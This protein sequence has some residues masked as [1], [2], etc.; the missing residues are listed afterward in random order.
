MAV[1]AAYAFGLLLAL[2]FAPTALAQTSATPPTLFNNYFVTGDYAVGGV[3]LRGSGDATGYAMGYITIPDPNYSNSTGVPAG[4]DIVGA[5]L[6]WQTVESSQT[7]FAGQQG[8]FRAL[9]A[10]TPSAGYP[11]TGFSLGN[12]NAPVSWSSG[13]CAGA[14][15]GSK[16]IRTYRADVRGYLPADPS[17]GMIPSTYQVRLADSGSNGGG[18]PL[19]LGATLVIIYR[20]LPAVAVRPLNAIVI[21]DGSYAPSNA[22]QTT[23]L[24]MQG[25]YQ[26]T[27]LPGT[28]VAKLTQ[29]VGNGQ[30]NKYEQVFI[31]GT[32]LTPANTAAF[33]GAYNGSWDNPTWPVTVNAADNSETISVVPSSSNAGCVSWGAVILSTT[34]QDSDSDGLLDI[35]EKN[36]GY[37]D[38]MDTSGSCDS[39]H[40]SWVDLSGA[41]PNKKDVFIQMDYMCNGTLNADGTC[42][43]GTTGHSHMPSAAAQSALQSAFSA[44]N[45]NVHIK[46]KNAILEQTC[47]DNLTA[48]PPQYC[49]YP[50]TAGTVGWKYGL[51]YIKYT[52]LNPTDTTC[53]TT[54]VCQRNF[55]YGR[56]DSYHYALFGHAL[57]LPDWSFQNGTL[58][59]VSVSGNVATF[60]TSTPIAASFDRVTIGSA[61]SNPNLNGIFLTTPAPAVGSTTF[62]ITLPTSVTGTVTYTKVT[63]PNLVVASDNLRSGSGFSD[64]G[65]ADSLITLGQWGADGTSTSTV[66]GTFMHELGHS[67]AL[68]HGGTYPAS[69]T[70]AVPLALEPNCKPNYQSVMNYLF[71]V[72]LLGSNGVLDYSS[73]QLSQLNEFSLP[74]S[75][76]TMDG[77]AIAFTSTKWYDLAAPNGVGTPATRHC[78]G[79][80]ILDNA[81]MYRIEGPTSPI[82]WSSN[83]LDI[84]FDGSQTTLRGYNDWA[85]IDLRQIGAT[86]SDFAGAGFYLGGGGIAFTGG[87]IAFTGGGIAFTGGGIAFTGGGIAFTGGGTG[88]IDFDTANSTV[89]PPRKLTSGVTSTL[90][91]SILLN[92]TAPSFGQITSYRIYKGVNAAPGTSPSYSVSGSPLATSYTDTAVVCG[93]LY[94]YFVT[95]V[96]Q[97]ASGTRESAPSNTVTQKACG[98]PYIFTGFY[99]PL[100]AATSPDPSGQD[101][102]Y[103]GAFNI[104]KSV[105]AKWTLQDGS[106]NSVGNLNANS[107]YAVP[108]PAGVA[109][110][111][112]QVSPVY[113]TPSASVVTLYS[114]SSGAK[115]NSTFRIS[116]SN[117]Q[118]IFNWDTT[119]FAAGCYVLELDLDSGQVER[120]ALKLQ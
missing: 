58:T 118:F 11:I 12:P 53:Q 111:P 40:S 21:Y 27:Q 72:D 82:A 14:S 95:A 74:S 68:T 47:T 78:D 119:A 105:T 81:R 31:N 76:T 64:I 16:T 107:L 23:S 79:T 100:S 41:D 75:I 69:A 73:Q 2:G 30:S 34:V 32:A 4:A 20:V 104:G 42:N 45:I 61:L 70:S 96:I 57:G 97:D 60:T 8:Y 39:T 120:T 99:S 10:G 94:Y 33:P 49:P 52:A 114:P 35:W 117:N 86:G 55:Q 66:S 108:V 28:P 29:I 87:G 1:T 17:T 25:F 106:G 54:G 115:G 56:K 22:A 109:C 26:P 62:S 46:V 93:P 3:G 91:R 18:A 7:S 6:Y 98:S 71:Q 84:N 83:G 89:R 90:P 38:A 44:H 48:T 80:P 67:L 50:G 5:F 65:G 77:S 36:Q 110:R 19:T 63:D 102:S 59:G 24:A 13:G 15:N 92:W 51:E 112:N 116:S 101:A 88:E 9:V 43:T 113:N 85:N 103:S 37:C